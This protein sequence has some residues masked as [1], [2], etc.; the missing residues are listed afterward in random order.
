[1]DKEIRSLSQRR[2]DKADGR[3]TQEAGESPSVTEEV[4]QMTKEETAL[5]RYDP[6]VIELEQAFTETAPTYLTEADKIL[7][8]VEDG[9]LTVFEAMRQ[10]N[11]PI[12]NLI[13]KVF[14][15]FELAP[16][17]MRR[18]RRALIAKS[19]ITHVTP[20]EAHSAIKLSQKEDEIAVR[21]GE[22]ATSKSLQTLISKVMDDKRVK[23]MEKKKEKED[24]VDES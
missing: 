24:S 11:A 17:E 15:K 21:T 1:M 16:E 14:D 6:A 23:K 8:R 10:A 4:T 18:L 22:G 2:P 19:L 20:E 3:S 5:V 9:E 12:R 13:Q 7:K